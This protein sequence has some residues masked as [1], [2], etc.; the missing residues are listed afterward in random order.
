MTNCARACGKSL[1]TYRDYE[2]GAKPPY[3]FLRTFIEVTECN[4]VW[5]LTGFGTIDGPA[6]FDSQVMATAFA[7][8]VTNSNLAGMAAEAFGFRVDDVG[9]GGATWNVGDAGE[10][11]GV[12]DGTEMTI[13]DLLLASNELSSAQGI[14]D[15]DTVLRTLANDVY[16]AINEGGDI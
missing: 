16:T 7:V 13:L 4:P 15:M 14:Y 3:E 10:A 2:K 1:T 8:Y 12:A 11:F 9:L 6:K 5:L